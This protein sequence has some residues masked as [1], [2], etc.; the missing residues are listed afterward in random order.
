[1][2][3][4]A[5]DLFLLRQL[6]W[7]QY[8]FPRWQALAALALTGILPYLAILN[9]ADTTD[10]RFSQAIWLG[11]GLGSTVLLMLVQLVIMRWWMRAGG[12]WDGQGKL[13]NLLVASSLFVS[14]LCAA[15]AA[16]ETPALLIFALQ[17]YAIWVEG[18][19]L[20]GAIPKAS[21]LY[22]ICGMFVSFA[23]FVIAGFFILWL[24]SVVF[25][26]EY[27]PFL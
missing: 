13:F 2:L 7:K 14:V 16:V 4:T 17:L 11:I 9:P 23:A 8:D 27:S 6:S 24:M 19:A 12:R 18:N 21:V 1:M 15:L 22:S 5:L 10:V 3:R 26:P 20:S 25:G